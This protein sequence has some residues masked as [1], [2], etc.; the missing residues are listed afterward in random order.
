MQTSSDTPTIEL[1][2]SPDYIA[3]LIVKMRGIQGREGLVDP[4][5]GSNPTDDRMIDTL[6]EEPG[7]LSRAEIFQEIAGLRPRRSS[8]CLNSCMTRPVVLRW[9]GEVLAIGFRLLYVLSLLNI[10][11]S[12]PGA[13]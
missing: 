3:R 1:A 13:K 11:T 6:Q 4:D 2:V 7:D 8:P 10:A 12:S 5:P 9:R